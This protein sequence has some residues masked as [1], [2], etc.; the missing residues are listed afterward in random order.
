MRFLKNKIRLAEEAAKR[1]K[2]PLKPLD[3]QVFM[4]LEKSYIAS[5]EATLQTPPPTQNIKKSKAKS[6]KKKKNQKELNPTKNIVINYGNAMA[7]FALSKLAI[8]YLQSSID[9]GELDLQGFLEFLGSSKG[10]ITGVEGLKSLLLVN[11]YDNEKVASYKKAFQMLCEVFI[12]YFSVNWI[13]H[14]KVTNKLVYLKY[15]T[16]VLIRVQ[17]PEQFT[18]IKE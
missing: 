1:L 2:Q 16:R 17:N 18:Y 3:S 4:T 9:K 12:K 8:P 5:P 13:I 6:Q 15:R 7:S 11:C 10:K 14:G